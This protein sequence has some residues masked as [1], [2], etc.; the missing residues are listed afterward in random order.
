MLN[1]IW[2]IIYLFAV[3]GEEHRKMVACGF[4]RIG[5]E[6]EIFCEIVMFYLRIT[7]TLW[8]ACGFGKVLTVGEADEHF[9]HFIP[10]LKYFTKIPNMKHLYE[11]WF[12]IRSLCS[13]RC[14]HV[15]HFCHLSSPLRLPFSPLTLFPWRNACSGAV[16]IVLDRLFWRSFWGWGHCLCYHC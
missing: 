3:L 5:I 16:P 7:M 15:L 1:L 10:L 9:Y 2:T 6:I 14:P 12:L 4:L 13:G 11:P 8:D